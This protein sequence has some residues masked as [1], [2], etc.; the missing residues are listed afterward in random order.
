MLP[1]WDSLASTSRYAT[2]FTDGT[3]IALGLLLILEILA[4]VYSTHEKTLSD[5]AHEAATNAAEK[6]K[7]D[8]IAAANSAAS[9]AKQ[10][11]ANLQNQLSARHLTTG[12]RDT[13]IGHLTN[14]PKLDVEM[15]CA[16]TSGD[17]A[18]EYGDEIQAALVAAGWPAHPVTMAAYSPVPVGIEIVAAKQ[19]SRSAGTAGVG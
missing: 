5:A 16:V 2:W 12:Q 10:D 13:L 9:Q 7:A 3:F 11:L 14:A 1:A 4:H 6:E 19:G 15:L 8:A 18:C 17:N